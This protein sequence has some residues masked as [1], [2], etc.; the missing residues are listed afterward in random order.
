MT[1]FTDLERLDLLSTDEIGQVN[2]QLLSAMEIVLQNVR[3]NRLPMG[4]VL[5]I[6]RGKPETV[7]A[8]R[9]LPHMAIAENVD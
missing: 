4:G 6:V 5:T 3:D 7:K 2:S 9:W 1:G 8:Y